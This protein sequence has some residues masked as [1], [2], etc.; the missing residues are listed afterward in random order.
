MKTKNNSPI[1]NYDLVQYK[2]DA[3]FEN[4]PETDYRKN[5]MEDKIAKLNSNLLVHNRK[6]IYYLKQKYVCCPQCSHKEVVENGHYTKK[7]IYM[8]KGLVECKVKRYVCKHCGTGF[9]ADISCIVDKNFS[10]SCDVKESVQKYYSFDHSSVRKIQEIMKEFHNV[11][12][13]HQEIQDIIV[14]YYIHYN[15][16]IK[17]FSGYYAF[18]ALWV[19]I[20]ELNDKWV[21]LLVLVD[22]LHDTVVAY[23]VVEHET[24]QEVYK[25]LREATRNQKRIGITTDLKKEYQRP[26]NDL[27]FKHQFCIFHFKKSINEHIYRYVKDNSLSDEQKKEFK[28]FLPRI[29]EVFKA[30]DMTKVDEIVSKLKEDKNDF[31][32][33]IKDI[34][35]KKFLPYVKYLTRFIDDFRIQSTSNIIE[36]IFEDLAPKH[37]K[38]K[39]KTL[40]GFLSRFNIKLKRWD[41]RNAVY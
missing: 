16:N 18:D 28:S 13:S 3:Y 23:K 8:D 26:I 15:P 12:L 6:G 9:S 31:P 5:Y 17:E 29:Y 36:R 14:D 37:V 33:V 25:F 35:D 4:L 10:I 27:K 7:L 11:E 19:K 24:E 41:H 32:Q 38:K 30:E 21:F 34:L 40:K 20:K 39:Y 22:T 1:F 2:L